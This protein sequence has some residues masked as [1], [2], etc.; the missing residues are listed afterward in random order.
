MKAKLEKVRSSS[1][2]SNTVTIQNLASLNHPKRWWFRITLNPSLSHKCVV[3][4]QSQGGSMVDWAW[5]CIV[6]LKDYSSRLGLAMAH[7][8]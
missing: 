5:F 6:N 2:L 7:Q 8:P 1:M 4:L 3:G